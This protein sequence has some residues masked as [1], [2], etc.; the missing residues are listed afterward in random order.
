[1]SNKKQRNNPCPCGS[2]LKFKRCCIN[3]SPDEIAKK[4]EAN[5]SRV[6]EQMKAFERMRKDELEAKVKTFRAKADGHI[7]KIPLGDVLLSLGAYSLLPQNQGKEMRFIQLAQDFVSKDSEKP[8]GTPHDLSE[9]LKDFDKS[10]GQEHRMAEID[11]VDVIYISWAKHDGQTYRM[12]SGTLAESE[13]YIKDSLRRMSVMAPLLKGDFANIGEFIKWSL[14]RVDR[15][16]E[17]AG[18]KQ[19][20]SSMTTDYEEEDI[21]SSS[22]INS[23]AAVL[24]DFFMIDKSS[25]PNS[26][27]KTLEALSKKPGKFNGKYNAQ[28]S[29]LYQFPVIDYKDSYF[30]PFPQLL[31]PAIF[32]NAYESLSEPDQEKL[33]TALSESLRIDTTKKLKSTFGEGKI[34]QDMKLDGQPWMDYC[35][36]FDGKLICIELASGG[37]TDN[38]SDLVNGATDKLTDGY[39]KFEADKTLEVS[40]LLGK[41]ASFEKMFEKLEPI[42]LVLVAQGS[43]DLMYSANGGSSGHLMDAIPYSHFEYLLKQTKDP[44]E[45]IRFL[46]AIERLRARKILLV[47]ATHIDMFS[48][49]KQGGLQLRDS[50][51]APNVLMLDLTSGTRYVSRKIK[52]Y[53]NKRILAEIDGKRVVL[54]KHWEHF[55][56]KTL[57]GKIHLYRLDMDTTFEFQVTLPDSSMSKE[58][59]SSLYLAFDSLC[60]FLDN[61]AESIYQEG[62]KPKKILFS[63]TPDKNIDDLKCEVV[64]DKDNFEVKMRVPKNLYEVFSDGTNKGEREVLRVFAKAYGIKSVE[65]W[66]DSVKP[67][68]SDVNF[69]SRQFRLSHKSYE[70]PPKPLVISPGERDWVDEVISKAVLQAGIKPG[71]YNHPKQIGGLAEK[72]KTVS[73]EELK[74]RLA[75]YPQQDVIEDAYTELESIYVDNEHQKYEVLSNLQTRKDEDVISKQI[76]KEQDFTQTSFAH[77]FLLELALQSSEEGDEL[78]SEEAYLELV[79]LAERV[80]DIDFWGDSTYYG[81]QPG[82]L[83]VSKAGYPS[84]NTTGDGGTRLSRLRF[85]ASLRNAEYRTQVREQYE[86]DPTKDQAVKPQL[87]RLD[88]VHKESFGFTLSE[89]AEVG[90]EILQSFDDSPSPII[91]GPKKVLVTKLAA[92]VKYS[93]ETIEKVID[94]MTLSRQMLAEKDISPSVRFW[95]EERIINRPLV[96]LPRNENVLL[97]SRSVTE[98]SILSFFDRLFTGRLEYLQN[99]QNSSLNKTVM[100]MI[101]ED[102]EKFEDKVESKVGEIGLETKKRVKSLAGKSVPQEVGDI[103][104]LF[105]SKKISKLF[106]AEEKN[107]TPSRSPVEIKTELDNYFGRDGKPGYYGQLKRKLDWVEANQVLVRQHF[108]ISD[109]VTFEIE[110]VLVTKS[111]VAAA[112]LKQ[113][114]YRTLTLSMFIEDL[115]KSEN[116]VSDDNESIKP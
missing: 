30:I 65:K 109:D 93:E 17:A 77:R 7:K 44:L 80:V 11:T 37:M 62:E 12:F 25:L 10:F 64:K 79:A 97:F 115:E 90:R 102:A 35:I 106:V 53:R 40:C 99:N 36:K 108:H 73:L 56:G 74:S 2:G 95:R 24:K 94:A 107:N 14:D 31:V 105:W 82:A 13:V 8:S 96:A 5:D 55:Y 19:H 54:R 110:G 6:N 88:A 16:I 3:I 48:L 28:W 29:E 21:H 15:F 98:R 91:M 66:V 33:T 59:R 104:G 103:D 32:Q 71:D 38:M 50:E 116:T 58:M 78:L 42:F 1:V 39:S 43:N 69:Q 49:F 60:Y 81:L 46:R 20:E 41:P 47:G 9:L 114:P 111:V 27:A 87:E 100:D 23:L 86:D 34:L 70:N 51:Q 22:D 83:H 75:K 67:L 26:I 89:R 57:H 92:K 112:V 72:I 101:N 4:R 85:E 18:L 84:I 52:S 61:H 76:S 45:F 68:S 63:V 113:P